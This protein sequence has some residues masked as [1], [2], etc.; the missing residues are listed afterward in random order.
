M[1]LMLQASGIAS[2]SL[3][4][5]ELSVLLSDVDYIMCV[6]VQCCCR[7]VGRPHTVTWILNILGQMW[8]D[9][10]AQDIAD[11]ELNKGKTVG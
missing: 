2:H 5:P 4:D 1:S 11:P 7:P 10:C 3:M 9:K 6:T 8:V